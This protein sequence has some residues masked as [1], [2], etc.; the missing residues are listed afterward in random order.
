VTVL[1][2]NRIAVAGTGLLAGL[3]NPGYLIFTFS[4][5]GSRQANRCVAAVEEV[6]KLK[7]TP[8]LTD[9]LPGKI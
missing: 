3:V 1:P 4:Q 9:D 8:D 6:M 7:D 2:R 5:T